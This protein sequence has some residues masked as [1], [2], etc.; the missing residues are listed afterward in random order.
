V[1]DEQ[2]NPAVDRPG[3]GFLSEKIFTHCQFD[4]QAAIRSPARGACS[5]FFAPGIKARA[6]PSCEFHILAHWSCRAATV[7]ARIAGK[8]A[9]ADR[10]LTGTGIYR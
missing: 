5:F 8:R 9:L 1:P 3:F 7:L 10:K 2:R 6:E 4:R